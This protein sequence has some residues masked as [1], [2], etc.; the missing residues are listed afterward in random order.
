MKINKQK[1]EHTYSI[2]AERRTGRNCI[3]VAKSQSDHTAS[4]GQTMDIPVPKLRAYLKML[5]FYFL[6]IQQAALNL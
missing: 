2:R 3:R 1:K 4:I 5:W 6:E